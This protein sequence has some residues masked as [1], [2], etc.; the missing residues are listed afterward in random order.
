MVGVAASLR[1]TVKPPH[2]DLLPARGEKEKGTALASPHKPSHN[3]V[4]RDCAEFT[5]GRTEGA[6][7][8]LHPG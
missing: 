6:T 4:D 7:L 5:I 2:P 8:W 3:C 1:L